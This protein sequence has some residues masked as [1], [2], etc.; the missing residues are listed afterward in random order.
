[1]KKST[2]F[3]IFIIIFLA[4][5]EFLVIEISS[6]IMFLADHTKKGDLSIGLVTEKAIDILQHPISAMSKL[7][8]ENNPIFYVGS[9]ALIISTLI[10]LFKT[11]KEKQDWEAETKNQTHGSARYA[12]NSEIFIPGRIEK[13]SK[14][15]MLKQFKKSLKKGND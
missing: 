12:T 10:V 14:K 8:A 9:A 1:M 15:Q 3:Y 2:P 6:L 7:I 13:V 11:P 5:L 4:F